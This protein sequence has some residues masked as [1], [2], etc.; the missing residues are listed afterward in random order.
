MALACT[1]R[2]SRI[3]KLAVCSIVAFIV[4]SIGARTSSLS[5]GDTFSPRLKTPRIAPIAA[6]GRSQAQ[7]QM[8]ASRPAYNIYT[9]LAH[10]P[11][12][13]SRW[14]GLGRFLLNGSSLQ[15][16]HREILMLRMGWLCQSEYEWA[17]HAR[18]ATTSAGMTD[19]EVHRIAEGPSAPGW[20]DFER[21][22]LRMVDEL[23]YEAIISEATWNALRKEYSDQKM[24]E[25]L[26]TAAQYQLVSMALNSLGVQLDPDLRHRLPKDVPLPKLAGHASGPRLRIPRIP[27][28][29]PA[30]WSPEQK[31]M[32]AGQIRSDGSVLNLYTTMI[33]HTGLYTPRTIFGTYLRAESSLPPKTRELLI[34]RTAFLIGTEYEWA[35]H[36]EYARTAGFTE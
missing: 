20:T 4:S 34:M 14:S 17:Q 26:Y 25:A 31:K 8:L 2:G 1:H 6:E 16:R 33:Q 9:T 15:A 3:T 22:L 21:N 19:Q 27:P 30:Q 10:H 23:R 36:A 11:E 24:M 29:T 28:L 12:L 35:H 5:S 32:I 13:Y 7:Q 18:I